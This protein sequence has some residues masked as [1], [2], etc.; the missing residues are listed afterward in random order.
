MAKGICPYYLDCS[1]FE[2]FKSDLSRK[3]RITIFHEFIA[4]YC[5]GA[6]RDTCHRF[7]HLEQ[8]GQPLADHIAP[9][10]EPYF[11]NP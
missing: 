5:F 1:F 3:D 10:G 7:L 9:N 11:S 6:L 2:R 4:V 8:T